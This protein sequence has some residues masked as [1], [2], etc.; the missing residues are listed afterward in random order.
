MTLMMAPASYV[1]GQP[2]LQVDMSALI[3][4]H[5]SILAGLRN[6]LVP[7]W[8]LPHLLP[9]MRWKGNIRRS[10]AVTHSFPMQTKPDYLV[11]MS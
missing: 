1:P 8:G 4:E 6:E 3:S 2:G 11:L 9:W 10:A 5:A 7:L